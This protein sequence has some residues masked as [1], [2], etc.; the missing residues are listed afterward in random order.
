M[1]PEPD[2]SLGTLTHEHCAPL[3]GETFSLRTPDGGTLELKLA[4]VKPHAGAR[5]GRRA[6]F[7]LL[8]RPADPQLLLPQQIY[9]LHH[10]RLGTL[11]IFL[12][13]IRPD[14]VG[15]R[16]EAVFT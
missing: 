1:S 6:P 16:I 14:S 3:I 5:P 12:V 13:Q 2:Y 7:S 4:E 8:F 11:D 9:P 15:P 10:P